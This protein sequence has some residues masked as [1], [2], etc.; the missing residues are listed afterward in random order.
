MEGGGAEVGVGAAGEGGG[1]KEVTITNRKG[2]A[3]HAQE[4]L[5][6]QLV[7]GIIQVTSRYRSKI[8]SLA[9]WAALP[10][11]LASSESE[12][13]DM[14]FRF[15]GGGIGHRGLGYG[16]RICQTCLFR[17]RMG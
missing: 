2:W 16:F 11:D 4:G 9:G 17:I 1:Y 13:P 8:L 14:L 15:Y 10:P 5:F 3:P 6:D 7:E 12:Q